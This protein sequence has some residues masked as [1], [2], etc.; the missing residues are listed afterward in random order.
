MNRQFL[1]LAAVLSA[2]AALTISCSSEQF[3]E[4]DNAKTAGN[5]KTFTLV[6][7]ASKPSGDALT[8]A[9]SE[10]GGA[11]N[12]LWAEGEKVYAYIADAGTPVEY[13]VQE[14]D[15][16]VTDKKKATLS[17]TFS[18]DGGFTQD[19]Q[20]VLY[21]QKEKDGYDDYSGQDGSI[22]KIASDYD[23]MKATITVDLTDGTSNGDNILAYSSTAFVRQQA[24]T[25]FTVKKKGDSPTDFPVDPLDI[26]PDG[27]S[28]L[29]ID[30]ASATNTIWVALPGR[31]ADASADEKSYK[32][33][34]T[35]E[36]KAYGTS[37]SV[38]LVNNKFY[39]A[40]LVMGR[41]AQ[42]ISLGSI[43]AAG[44]T[45]AYTGSAVNVGTV[46]TTGD[47]S[48][49]DLVEG[50]DYTV[51]YQKKNG[52][53]WEDCD[54]EDVKKTGTYKAIVS[55]IG[56]FEG[57]E[58][59]EFTIIKMEQSAVE[60]AINTNTKASSTAGD[61]TTYVSAGGTTTIVTS[62]ILGHSA[63]EIYDG[64]IVN[65]NN[66]SDESAITI[67]AGGLTPNDTEWA[68]ITDDGQLEVDANSGGIITVTI[69]IPAT[70][71]HEAA[72]VTKTYY[73]K[74]TGIGGELPDPTTGTW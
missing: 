48:N 34:T 62:P 16:D 73:V 15:I 33:E 10:S 55:G 72:T 69:Y 47:D 68:R 26:T 43:P 9:L 29:N 1:T 27:G 30:P 42:K 20:I 49:S 54:A 71:D 24:I 19:D 53:V 21:Y 14:A 35:S 40:E 2:T 63:D 36:S 23:R 57:T 65:P 37:K 39:T 70:D 25:K 22:E 3:P 56:D 13:T 41:D 66:S 60:A 7:D 45:Q 6:V 11:L 51:T 64:T 4:N 17:F 74:Q 18:K 52:D 46:S 50:T 12:T 67:G 58:E 44:G 31:S 59:S 28:V 61:A 38:D 8:R 5:V 32:F